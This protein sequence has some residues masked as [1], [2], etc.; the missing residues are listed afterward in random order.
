MCVKRCVKVFSPRVRFLSRIFCSRS[1]RRL[2]YHRFRSGSVSWV[3]LLQFFSC[4]FDHKVLCDLQVYARDALGIVYSVW[5]VG[6][7]LCIFDDHTHH[8]NSSIYIAV[9]IYSGTICCALTDF[10]LGSLAYFQWCGFLKL[11]VSFLHFVEDTFLSIGK[12][13][14]AKLI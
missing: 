2:K 5:S 4:I 9:I 8:G 12:K 14:V 6:V 7:R 1:G 10:N 3:P 11:S 13:W